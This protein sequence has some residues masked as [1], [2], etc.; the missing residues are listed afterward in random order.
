M[1][2]LVIGKH[3]ARN[4][5]PWGRGTKGYMAYAPE[6]GRLL[7]VK[8]GW[9][10]TSSDVT[11]ELATYMHLYEKGVKHI[12]QVV[13]GSDVCHGMDDA[14]RPCNPNDKARPKLRTISQ[15]SIKS[16]GPMEFCERVQHR[17]IFETIGIPLGEYA[18][19]LAM[20]YAVY[21]AFKSALIAAYLTCCQLNS[22][23]TAAAHQEAW[24]N[25]E[26]LHRDVSVGN[27]LVDIASKDF[28]APRAVLSDWDLSAP[29]GMLRTATQHDRVVSAELIRLVAILM[30][31]PLP[32]GTWPFMSGPMLKYP[33]KPNDLPDDIESFVHLFYYLILRY[34]EHS[35]QAAPDHKDANVPLSMFVS[36]YFFLAE[37]RGQCAIGGRAKFE[38]FS[39]PK[40]PFNLTNE[41]DS[42]LRTFIQSVH[43]LCYKH[44]LSL[45]E[46]LL[47]LYLPPEGSSKTYSKRVPRP[48]ITDDSSDDDFTFD[49]N[50]IK[51]YNA[52]ETS[53]TTSQRK[54]PFASHKVMRALLKR[55]VKTSQGGVIWGLRDKTR[56][57]FEGLQSLTLQPDIP[58]S[59]MV[60]PSSKRSVATRAADKAGN[61]RGGTKRRTNNDSEEYTPGS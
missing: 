4:A 2:T 20:I 9:R 12:P 50:D 29:K 34:H 18:N 61:S 42:G 49:N 32:Q 28:N 36:N 3:H 10:P 37:P 45:D 52:P 59:S 41:H 55:T 11:S 26:I 16:D 13:G 35:L 14:L 27:I 43:T 53:R 60:L 46:T 47:E 5:S 25:A 48:I 24:E 58:N 15:Q 33:L 54:D 23:T 44:Y 57:Q 40:P 30:E 22:T 39:K 1:V 8:M 7:F 31:P 6:L 51:E 56:D 21:Q 38:V 19:A 17:L